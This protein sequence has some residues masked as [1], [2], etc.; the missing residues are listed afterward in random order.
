MGNLTSFSKQ[1]LNHQIYIRAMRFLLQALAEPA[2]VDLLSSALRALQLL[3]LD[4]PSIV[5]D[6]PNLTQTMSAIAFKQNP[7]ALK[8]EAI[9]ALKAL[10]NTSKSAFYAQWAVVLTRTPSIFDLLRSSTRVAKAAADLLT[11]IFRDTWKFLMIADNMS[12]RSSFT[13]LAQQIGD[14]VDVCFDRFLGVLM[15]SGKDKL[16]LAVF[17]RASKA[18]ATFVR[19]CSFDSGHLKS[20]YIERVVEWCKTVLSGSPEEALI[21]MKSLL[22]TDITF[23]PFTAAFDTLF[24]TFLNYIDHQNPNFSKPARFALCRMAFAYSNEVVSRYSILGPKLRAIGPIHSLPIL[25]RLAEKAVT[26]R[27]VWLDILEFHVP[28]SFE[29]RHEKS[30]E[31]SLQCI[32]LS[33]PVFAMLPD[34]LQRFCCAT[35][36]SADG[37]IAA[38]A[39]GQLA[40]STA[41]DISSVFLPD[42]LLKLMEGSTHELRALSN[43]LETYALRRADDFRP[44]W[45]VRS[46]SILSSGNSPFRPR[47]LGFLFAF[48]D[49]RSAEAVQSLQNLVDALQDPEPK[50]RW[51]AAAAFAVAFKFGAV[52]EPAIALL[53]KAMESDRF[54]KVK[55][56]AAAAFLALTTRAQIGELFH[57]L[58]LLVLQ[59]L[60]V[61]AHFTNLSIVMHRKYNTAY[62]TNLKNLFLVVL[63]WT[64]ARDFAACEEDLV[65]NVDAIYELLSEEENAPWQ[66]ITRLYEAKFNSIPSK[67]L[68]KFQERAFPV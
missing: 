5:L 1:E 29:I 21:V 16:E 17:N 62:K 7:V 36:L 49:S 24:Q 52:S 19:N 67:T 8:F 30:I 56:K 26:D 66:A 20:G 33:G 32:G 51:N 35:I 53:L 47:C 64:T 55:I 27:T 43:V 61:P 12:Q 14:I 15:R 59:Q 31:R 6:P 63:R 54:A 37:P 38:Q 39:V 40:R 65:G 10:A 57:P 68:E 2:S 3:I 44:E 22:W 13:T 46:L 48:L 34:N 45:V 42:A 25:L 60:L 9:M 41:A 11:D 23:P 18:F 58:F 28:T 50:V 4:A